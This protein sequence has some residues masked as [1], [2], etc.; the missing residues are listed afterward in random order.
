MLSKIISGG[1]TGAD[2][3]ALDF[4]IERGIPHGGWCPRG[5]LAEDGPISENYALNE[6]PSSDS[7]QRTEWNV[8]DSD[9]TV[10]FSVSGDLQ[11]GS[12]LTIE[13]A[14]QSKKPYLHISRERDGKNAFTK[15]S[16]FLA[17]HPIQILNIAG[18]R[19]SEEPE[20]VAFVREVLRSCFPSENG[21]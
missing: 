4:A 11:G 2:R 12:K 16:A 21:T 10:I 20:I 3:A 9:A 7:S 18:S 5:R 14:V 1:Q 19:A 17:Q 8:R 6:T 15:L 13:F